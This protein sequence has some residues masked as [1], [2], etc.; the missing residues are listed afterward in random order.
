MDEFL[1]A[2]E[3]HSVER[4]QAVLDAGLDPNAPIRGS[5]VHWLLRCTRWTSSRPVCACY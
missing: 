3:L 5:A 4:L 2:C 1:V